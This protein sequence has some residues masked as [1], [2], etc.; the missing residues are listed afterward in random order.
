VGSVRCFDVQS[1][2]TR[3]RMMET[4]AQ[5]GSIANQLKIQAGVVP[6]STMQRA[7]FAACRFRLLPS[8][9]WFARTLS[10]LIVG[11]SALKGTLLHTWRC[12]TRNANL[13]WSPRYR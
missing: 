7:T 13:A 12:S 8:S 9:R 10:P 6:C 11:A 4:K 1:R 5:M 3:E 2:K